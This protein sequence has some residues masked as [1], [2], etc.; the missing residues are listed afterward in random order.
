MGCFVFSGGERDVVFSA[1]GKGVLLAV[2]KMMHGFWQE[3]GESFWTSAIGFF[4]RRERETFLFS[5][6][7]KDGFF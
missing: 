1:A 2:G 5:A 7:G 4:S 6:V 3:G